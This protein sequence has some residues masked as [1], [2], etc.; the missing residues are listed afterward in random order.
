MHFGNHF[1]LQS[2]YKHYVH[3]HPVQVII[4]KFIEMDSKMTEV[5]IL[6]K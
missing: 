5:D 4:F 1:K 6:Y 2:V 3:D